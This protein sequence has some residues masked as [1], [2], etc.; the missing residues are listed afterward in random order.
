MKT[1]R[2]NA[3]N[4][5][6]MLA[7][8]LRS[9]FDD[10][11]RARR[12]VS[13]HTV[14][15]YRDAVKLFLNYAAQHHRIRVQ[16]LGLRHLDVQTVLGFLDYLERE[17]GVSISTRNHRLAALRS[18]FGHLAT[19]NPEYFHQCHQ[20]LAVP[21]K[22]KTHHS[23]EYLS[24]EE[25]EGL[26]RQPDQSTVRGHRDYVLLSLLYNTGCRVQEILQ[27]RP[28]D[29]YLGRPFQVRV[30]GKGRKERVCPLWPQTANLIKNWL[31]RREISLAGENVLFLNQRGQPL[32]RFGVRYIVQSYIQVAED[33]I[34]SLKDKRVHPHTL[35]HTTAM[36]LLQAGVEVN[37][38]R[39]ILGHASVTTTNHYA[40]IDLEMK[41]K[42]I[43]TV[44]PQNRT[45]QHQPNWKNDKDLMA[46][47]ESL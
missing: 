47:L 31:M 37:M 26:L 46:W 29:L 20:V 19:L 33:A 1:Y 45:Q 9:F 38:I 6:D 28:C 3:M 24:R 40:Q 25:M 13:P 30:L 42:A 2:G 44:S 7:R 17:R 11:L 14:L 35:R 10:Y 36:H 39:S 34:P 41:R 15:A 22:R 4:D 8:G 21:F 16:T 32:T 18:L 5:D 23:V 27:L 43:E 12:N